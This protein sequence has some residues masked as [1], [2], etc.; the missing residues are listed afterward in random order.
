MRKIFTLIFIVT[1]FIP[2][3]SCA[4]KRLPKIKSWLCFY[5]SELPEDTPRYDLYIFSNKFFPD[6]S[7]IKKKRKKTKVVGYISVG[8]ITVEN[9]SFD[10]I[11]DEKILID[12]NKN[13]PGSYRANIA[14]DKWQNYLLDEVVPEILGRG[15]DGLFLDTIDTAQY[16]E[17]D[18]KMRGQIQG[19]V[20][21][22]KKMREKF[23]DIVIILNGGLFMIDQVGKEIDAVVVEDVY[24][25]YDFETKEYRLATPEWTRERMIPLLKFQKRFKKPVLSLDYLPEN[26]EKAIKMVKNNAKRDGFVPYISDIHL[27]KIFF[28]P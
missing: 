7:A 24:T 8:E 12:E 25:L 27:Q 22:I 26:D 9:P 21:L 18:K 23:P 11:R 14:D 20:N 17:I 28:H 2:S 10:K 19:A 6:F 13:W 15:F 5:G 3:T 4:S 1:F 16:L